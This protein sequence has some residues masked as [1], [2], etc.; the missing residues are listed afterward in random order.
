MIGKVVVLR[1]TILAGLPE[2]LLLGEHEAGDEFDRLFGF[3][4][5]ALFQGIDELGH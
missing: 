1:S 3:L 5:G 4:L 2:L